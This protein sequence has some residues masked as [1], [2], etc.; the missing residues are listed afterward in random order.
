MKWKIWSSRFCKKDQLLIFYYD[1]Q[2]VWGVGL[3]TRKCDLNRLPLGNNEE[4]WVLRSDGS[5]C[6]NGKVIHQLNVMPDECD[7]IVSVWWLT[8]CQLCYFNIL[9]FFLYNLS[10]LAHITMQNYIFTLMDVKLNFLLLGL[11]EQFIQLYMVSFTLNVMSN[12]VGLGRYKKLEVHKNFIVLQ[13][14]INEISNVNSVQW[15]SFHFSDDLQ[16]SKSLVN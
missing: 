13:H 11:E 15:H 14:E 6:H 8:S 9:T 3:A 12:H 5:M 7:I 16:Y 1:Y 2:G 4:S 10:R